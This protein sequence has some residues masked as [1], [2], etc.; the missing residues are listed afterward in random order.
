MRKFLVISPHPDD[1][2]FG[3]AGTIAQLI[4]QGNV[5][6]ELIISDEKKIQALQAHKSQFKETAQV[7]SFIERMARDTGKKKGYRYAE[8]FRVLRLT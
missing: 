7:R 4:K 3:C 2:D 8:A 5:V 1:L 6:E